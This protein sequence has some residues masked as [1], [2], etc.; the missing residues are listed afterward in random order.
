MRKKR[1]ALVA[2]PIVLATSLMGFIFIRNGNDAPAEYQVETA[3]RG[4]IE[5]VVETSG[6]INP[7]V[8]VEIGSQVS[9]KIV[10]LGADF[11]SRVKAGQ[12]V[13]E[14]DQ[15]LLQRKVASSEANY[16]SA[17]ASLE[18][19]KVDLDLTKKIYE[20]RLGLFERQMIS[21]EDKESA[22]ADYVMAQVAVR[23][24]E[25]AVVQAK[26]SLDSSRVDLS[27]AVIRTPIDG[28]VLERS[29]N[30]G[31]TVASGYSV[32]VLFKVADLTKMQVECNLDEADI[33]RVKE[34]QAARFTVDA[35][36][37]EM[38]SGQVKQVRYAAVTSSNVVTY[39]VIIDAANPDLLLR[40]GMTAKVSIVS[41][42]ARNALQVAN[43]AL[44][45]TPAQAPADQAAWVAAQRRTLKAGSGIVW[46]EDALGALRAGVVRTGVAGSSYTE[47]VGG[48]VAL[49]AKVVV[50]LKSATSATTNL[51][52]NMPPMFLMDGGPPPPPPSK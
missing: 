12:V 18:R 47:I 44:R 13:A 28:I 5:A 46:T 24:A 34:G 26:S 37:D 38:F 39:T 51:A 33:G 10:K 3:G 2:A 14:L 25:S 52:Q 8:T 45:F 35:S 4:D 9:G 16:Q 31:Q 20:R 40:P 42:E 22:E 23:S 7:V 41:A 17:L 49:G 43:T 32:P 11:N 6:T 15:D 30:I 50:G 21:A 19:A 48:D 29:V 27:Y 1:A 36:A